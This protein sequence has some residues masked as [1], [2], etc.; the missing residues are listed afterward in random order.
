MV[1]R[2]R[3]TLW[4]VV[5]VLATTACT[6]SP[7]T[8]GS[9][10]LTTRA[11]TTRPFPTPTAVPPPSSTLLELLNGGL[12]QTYTATYRIADEFGN[13]MKQTV[14]L[15]RGSWAIDQPDILSPPGYL[16]SVKI[17]MRGSTLLECYE[18][19]AGWSCMAGPSCRSYGECQ[20][21]RSE[22]VPFEVAAIVSKYV[23]SSSVS[24]SDRVI[25]G[26]AASCS[27]AAGPPCY[28]LC[29]TFSGVP[30]V[31]SQS[32][33]GTA[34]DWSTV[35]IE[36]LSRGVVARGLDAP[37]A[38]FAAPRCR[39]S[40]LA[41]TASRSDGQAG[42]ESD[43]I[44]FRNVT[45]SSCTLLGYPTARFVDSA[46]GTFGPASGMESSVPPTVVDLG[47]GGAASTTV[48]TDNP[49]Y[50]S[51]P[52]KT[53]SGLLVTFADWPS[54]VSVTAPMPI[55]AKGLVLGTTPV[56]AG[57]DPSPE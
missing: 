17:I 32:G 25:G 30:L 54:G 3:P 27:G 42:S 36:K 23:Q 16:E 49:T 34:N 51:C 33:Y 50:A 29:L 55:C 45:K 22:A 9:T 47:P 7:R 56:F 18:H 12:R 15:T 53:S 6:S 11:P 52:E 10:T 5:L 46:G 48:W 41:V 26:R 43:L 39:P 57:G 31:F 2:V 40:E 35:R 19:N 13:V 38:Q 21:W 14:W 24:T 37:A 1:Q 44:V 8:S 28:S 20:F 4:L